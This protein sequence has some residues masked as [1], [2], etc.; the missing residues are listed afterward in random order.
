MLRNSLVIVLLIGCGGGGGKSGVSS[1]KHIVDLNATE[2]SDFCAYEVDVQMAPRTVDCGNGLMVTLKDKAACV[3]S[4]AQF[5]AS[6]T[7][8]VS[9]AETC[10][11]A[12][13]VDPCH[14][15]GSACTP[16]LQCAG[17]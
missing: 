14:F 4:F 16:I 11:E 6:C 12:V 17:G 3:A 1:D 15:G 13:G 9:Q 5:I 8:T 2:V 10:A 7:A